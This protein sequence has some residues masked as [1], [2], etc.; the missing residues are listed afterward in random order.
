MFLFLEIVTVLKPKPTWISWNSTDPRHHGSGGYSNCIFITPANLGIGWNSLKK[1]WWFDDAILYHCHFFNDPK[2]K[3]P[4]YNGG[5][6]VPNNYN[7]AKE[8]YLPCRFVFDHLQELIFRFPTVDGPIPANPVRVVKKNKAFLIFHNK[9]HIASFEKEKR[10]RL[11]KLTL[12]PKS[13]LCVCVCSPRL[14]FVNQKGTPQHLEN[15]KNFIITQELFD[16]GVKFCWIGCMIDN[17]RLEGNKKKKQVDRNNFVDLHRC[18]PKAREL[19]FIFDKGD[20]EVSI[21]NRKQT[22]QKCLAISS[23]SNCD[24]DNASKNYTTLWPERTMAQ[25]IQQIFFDP[26][27]SKVILLH[28]VQLRVALKQQRSNKQTC[29]GSF[30]NRSSSVVN[31]CKH[32][33]P[34][35]WDSTWSVGF[36]R[37]VRVRPKSLYLT[38]CVTQ[39]CSSFFV[40]ANLVTHHNNVANALSEPK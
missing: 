14:L 6:K 21:N 3:S 37:K 5:L 27:S 23:N 40:K 22:S 29:M 7:S 31:N 1:K 9:S 18:R 8:R 4:S 25:C 33:I 15:S 16:P 13:S 28:P 2:N 20:A 30:G 10:H 17:L 19:S 36:F 34:R 35:Q 12:F 38:Q 32:M 26:R 11:L 24:L 39:A